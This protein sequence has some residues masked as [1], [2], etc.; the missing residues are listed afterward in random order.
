M[1]N[2]QSVLIFISNHNILMKFDHL[3]HTHKFI[4]RVKNCFILLERFYFSTK[5][6]NKIKFIMSS[7]FIYEIDPIVCIKF[8]TSYIAHL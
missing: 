4:C 1:Y 8:L 5:I 6:S 2:L 3:D 7:Y